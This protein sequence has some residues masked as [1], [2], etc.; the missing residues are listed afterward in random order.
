MATAGSREYSHEEIITC[1]RNRTSISS[2]PTR[3][4]RCTDYDQGPLG[5]VVRPRQRRGSPHEQQTVPS[6]IQ[7]TKKCSVSGL[8]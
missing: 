8:G 5:V 2:T 7:L 6:S 4:Q 3:E 1:I